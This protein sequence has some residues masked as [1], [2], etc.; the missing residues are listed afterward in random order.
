P[1]SNPEFIIGHYADNHIFIFG[2]IILFAGLLLSYGWPINKKL[3]SPTFVLA[4]CGFGSFFLA[5]LIWIIDIKGKQKWSLFFEAF[6][7]NPLY[8]YVQAAI[9]TV[10]LGKTGIHGYIY[11]ELLV[12][13]AGN[14]N[15]SLVWAIL[16]VIINWIPGYWLY[17]KHIYI[18]YNL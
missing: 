9:F 10:I 13:L 3:W 6:G 18:N 12:P 5:L 14:Y 7:I 1:T 4:T 11:N 2:T 16:F 15:G 17:K 8:L